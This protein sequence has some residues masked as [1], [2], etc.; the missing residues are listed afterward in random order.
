MRTRVRGT[1]LGASGLAAITDRHIGPAMA[2]IHSNPQHAW[3]VGRLADKVGLSRSRF[4]VRFGRL[5]GE[6]PKAYI[7]RVRMLRAADML[8]EGSV[9]VKTI[10]LASGYES[11]SSF[12]KAF[13]RFFRRPPGQFRLALQIPHSPV[14][15]S[16][17]TGDEGWHCG[18]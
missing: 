4:T 15:G 17:V 18:A 16:R 7:A 6:P 3:T 5:V 14:G 1:D 2:L 9:S 12:N 13:K 8:K 11:E 10:A